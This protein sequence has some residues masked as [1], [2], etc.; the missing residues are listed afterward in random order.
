MEDQERPPLPIDVEVSRVRLSQ[1]EIDTG[2][3]MYGLGNKG[4]LAVPI[5]MV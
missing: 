2:T 5:E 1:D 3:W 4:F